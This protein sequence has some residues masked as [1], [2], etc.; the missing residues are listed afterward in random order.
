MA[1]RDIENTIGY[2]FYSKLWQQRRFIEIYEDFR[3]KHNIETGNYV[4]F[5]GGLF[6]SAVFSSPDTFFA[7][8]PRLCGAIR[9]AFNDPSFNN[10]DDEWLL[11]FGDFY[12]SSRLAKFISWRVS[13]NGNKW[14]DDPKKFFDNMGD[15]D[16]IKIFMRALICVDQEKGGQLLRYAKALFASYES[17][18]FMYNKYEEENYTPL[19]KQTVETEDNFKST[20]KSKF[21]TTT[22]DNTYGFNSSTPV[23]TGGSETSGELT[24]NE[25]VTE[26]LKTDN[27]SKVVTSYDGKSDTRV[28]EGY[29]TN[30]QDA[31]MKELDIRREDFMKEFKKAIQQELFML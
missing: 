20:S 29:N 12:V 24:D 10:F 17:E 31:L 14:D 18:N 25:N 19:A 23:P 30:I 13:D 5:N 15:T 3:K 28:T 1:N 2:R 6:Q 8:C 22:N 7:M 26:G 4:P 21:K 9:L 16:Y 27:F 11:D